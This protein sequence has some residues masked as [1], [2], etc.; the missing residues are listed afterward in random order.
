MSF[1]AEIF[2]SIYKWNWD[3]RTKDY[4]KATFETDKG[5]E[6]VVSFKLSDIK[7]VKE[8]VG[9]KFW[10]VEF[11]REGSISITGDKDAFKIFSTVLN[12]TEKFVKI[13]NFR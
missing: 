5:H 6:V 11:R 4:L 2:N 12:I 1:L 8:E 7:S 3:V 13:S 10:E 9:K